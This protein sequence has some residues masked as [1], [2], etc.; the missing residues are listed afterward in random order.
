VVHQT[1]LKLP[2]SHRISLAARA[3]PRQR[4]FLR[5]DQHPQ[6][7]EA[8]THN[9]NLLLAE[10][11]ALAASPNL[12]QAT[13]DVL[14]ADPRWA[15][16]DELRIALAVHPSASIPFT[17]RIVAQLQEPALRR[18]LARPSLNMALRDKI[19]KRLGR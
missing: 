3:G 12:T 13:I 6:V 2:V 18:L 4:E 7:L 17:E 16:D 5:R 9:P 11:R 14:A 8:L 10:A 15:H 19:V 1:L